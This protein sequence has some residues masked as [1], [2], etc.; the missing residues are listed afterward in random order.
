MSS[1]SS[2]Y[3][4]AFTSFTNASAH[5]F[6]SHSAH[7][8]MSWRTASV[9]CWHFLTYAAVAMSISFSVAQGG[10]TPRR[11]VCTGLDDEAGARQMH[12]REDAGREVTGHEELD[13]DAGEGRVLT[14]LFQQQRR[15]AGDAEGLDRE[16]LHVLRTEDVGE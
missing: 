16:G 13:V 6:Q 11:L 10:L 5:W 3:S 9:C 4:P 15:I 14:T 12:R 7:S 2:S 8:R 1:M